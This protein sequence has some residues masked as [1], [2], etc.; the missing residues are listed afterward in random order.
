[1]LL[2]R[3]IGQEPLKDRLRHLLESGGVG[4]AYVFSGPD[5]TG[6]RTVAEAFATHL[7]CGVS[8]AAPCG[9]C[10]GCRLA[11]AGTHP[12]LAT[13]APDPEK[14]R[15]VVDQIRQLQSQMSI[16][17]VHGRKV[18]LL[19]EADRM[20]ESA[21]N[22]LLKSL[23]EP[24]PETVLVMTA[25]RFDKLLP[26]VQSRS[27]RLELGR[28]SIEDM[29]RILASQ[30][31]D[32]ADRPFCLNYA[33]GIPGRAARMLRSATLAET[34]EKALA[35]LPGAGGTAAADALHALLSADKSRFGEAID[36]LITAWRDVMMLR[37]GLDRRLINA[38]KRGMIGE[39]VRLS[40]P[41]SA[42]RRIRMLDE[43]R[44]R[45]DGNLNYQLAV[46][47]FIAAL[48]D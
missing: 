12:D 38:D 11:A 34:R 18:M 44:D 36:V 13:V 41:E 46:D 23:E 20:N 2:N 33:D 29:T 21:Q 43:W 5:G 32:P 39:A 16:R 14:D 48:S 4:H 8:P 24:P 31:L 26:T 47:G 25:I 9:A 42:Q 27:I 28:Y 37:E 1:M 40:R 45:L 10:A 6:R 17:P 22:C 3:I 7:L 19:L 35:T 15:I 30:G